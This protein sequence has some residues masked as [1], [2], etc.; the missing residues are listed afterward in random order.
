MVNTRTGDDVVTR[1]V[2]LVRWWQ[3]YWT[4]GRHA[5][6]QAT[7]GTS[8]VAATPAAKEF[9]AAGWDRW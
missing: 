6:K 5:R 1:Q 7:T 9:D 4:P 3:R 2:A 8:P